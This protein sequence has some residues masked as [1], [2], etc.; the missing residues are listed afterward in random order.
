MT[1]NGTKTGGNIVFFTW[2]MKVILKCLALFQINLLV[3]SLPNWHATE[4]L[5]CMCFSSHVH[6]FQVLCSSWW[7]GKGKVLAWS[8]QACWQNP[9]RNCKHTQQLAMF[10]SSSCSEVPIWLTSF[11]DCM[12]LEWGRKKRLFTHAHPFTHSHL[13]LCPDPLEKRKEG[14]VF[15]MTFLVTWGMVERRKECNYCIPHA[16]HAY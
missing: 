11:P 16:L 14:L 15:W 7:C 3:Y 6:H 1:N 2:V 4:V 5:C 12:V 10:Y 8:G 13:V 9:H